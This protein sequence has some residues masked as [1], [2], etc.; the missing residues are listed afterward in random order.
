M[1]RDFAI[2]FTLARSHFPVFVHT[3]QAT[4]L[5]LVVAQ[6]PTRQIFLFLLQGQFSVPTTSVQFFLAFLTNQLVIVRN[7]A[8]VVRQSISSKMIAQRRH[9]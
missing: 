3:L 1:D 9:R 6:F 2:R 8:V 7:F 5:A 4:A